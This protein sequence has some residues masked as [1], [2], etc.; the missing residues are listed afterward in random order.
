MTGL[1]ISNHENSEI[2]MSSQEYNGPE[3]FFG[4]IGAVGTD[5]RNVQ[6]V[7][8]RELQTVSYLPHEI[9]L[10]SLLKECEKYQ[11]LESEDNKPEHIRIRSYMDCGDDFRK[12]SGRGDAVALLAMGKVRD[13]RNEMLDDPSKPVPGQAYVFNSLKH[14]DEVDTLRRVY[15]SAFFSISVYE[16][17]ET[18]RTSLCEKIA[19]SSNKYDAKQF[20]NEADELIDRDQKDASDDLGQNVRDTFPKADLFLNANDLGEMEKQIRRFVRVLFGFPF[21]SPTIDEFCMFHAK[22]AG[23]HPVPKTPS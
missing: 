17:R 3:L 19:K 13:L 12:V 7:L 1:P 22:A 20:E 21:A 14:P 18:R 16:S 6:S 10:S 11:H 15:G 23:L 8:F 5:L 9:R 4:L 2:L